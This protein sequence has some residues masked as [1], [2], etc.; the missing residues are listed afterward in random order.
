MKK[1]STKFGILFLLALLFAAPGI[2]AYLFFQHPNWLGASTVN[3][4]TFL[5][6]PQLLTALGVHNNKW[7][8][9]FWSPKDCDNACLKQLDTLARVRLA[10]G[11]KLY[12][13][14]QWFVLGEKATTLT[15][16]EK[17]LLH[18]LDFQFIQLA[19]L[20]DKQNHNLP[21]E[22]AVFLVNPDNYLILKYKSEVAPDDVFKDLK[23][24]VNAAENK[25]V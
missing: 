25:S 15:A 20:K 21:A 11:R 24:L 14:D 6:P 18:E 22:P 17:T 2:T 1:N 12:Y 23:L 3:R 13:V 7:H 4:G 19:A 5:K 9:L 16:E 8:I 10:L